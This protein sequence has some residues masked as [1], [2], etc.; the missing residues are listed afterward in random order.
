MGKRVK[1][2]ETVGDLRRDK[3]Y[4]V[5]DENGNYAQV[6]PKTPTERIGQGQKTIFESTDQFINEFNAYMIDIVDNGYEKLPTKLDFA[7]TRKISPATVQREYN[8]LTANEKKEW[9]ANLSDV[10]TAGV[11]LGKYNTT[12]S[13]FAL[14]NWCNWADKNEQKVETSTKQLVSKQEAKDQ[15]RKYSEGLKLAK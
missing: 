15:L 10:I 11:N 12:M 13:I 4:R 8:K 6:N 3:P 5:I 14:K 9:Q 7:I 1:L 2:N